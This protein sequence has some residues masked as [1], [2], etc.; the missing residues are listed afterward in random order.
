MTSSST[1]EP[2]CTT[3]LSTT[4]VHVG[5]D[6]G[7]TKIE[8]ILLNH[9]HT[10]IASCRM[11]AHRGNTAVVRDI[12]ASIHQ[13]T[14][15][16]DGQDNYTVGIGIPGQVDSYSGTVTGAVN[17]SI[18]SLDLAQCV[19]RELCHAT[20]IHVENDVNA[21][22]L[23]AS[24]LVDDVHQAATNE[25]TSV[26][27]NLGTGLAAG[28]VTDGR[29]VHGASGI[30]GEIGHI[31]VE[32][33]AL[34]CPCGQR[35]CLETVGSGSAV[36]RLWPHADGPA[37]PDLIAHAEAGDTDAQR[38][39]HMI[40]DAQA[41][42]VIIV[43]L[44]VDPAHILIGGGLAKTGEPLLR[45]L[46]EAIQ[47]KATDSAFLSS[48]RLDERLQLVPPDQPVGAI[49]AALSAVTPKV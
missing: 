36:E 22:A 34:P 5:V 26:F 8:T 49:G 31:P 16:L 10:V 38:I 9:D 45:H 25:D 39:L 47:T 41:T 21:A 30:C 24:N 6:V 13:V 1:T 27:I 3:R 32:P 43:G 35:G 40:S 15:H 14:T 12:V 11:P 28:I 2:T 44:T 33:H 23:G 17:L 42:A 19:K 4:R 29:I 37:M 7:G 46:K 20:T 48:A 18:T